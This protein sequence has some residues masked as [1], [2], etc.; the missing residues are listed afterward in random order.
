MRKLKKEKNDIDPE[1]FVCV[2]TDWTIF[3]FNNFKTSLD[4]VSNIYRNKKLLEDA[5]KKQS[6]IKILL[7]KLRKYNL[8]KL[9]DKSQRRNLKCCRK[10]VK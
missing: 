8:T 3:N 9:K 4:L 7:K 10:I 2:K 6:E 1:N 5:E